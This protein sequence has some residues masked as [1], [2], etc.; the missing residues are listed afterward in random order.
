MRRLTL[1][2][3]AVV[4]A[5]CGSSRAKPDPEPGP[6]VTAPPGLAPAATVGPPEGSL[7]LLAP[8]GAVPD[9]A[10][11]VPGCNVSVTSV[12]G[13]D[14]VVRKLSTGR[15][16]A[17][18]G[19]GDA[20]VRLV[21][22]QAIAPVNVKLIRNY[23][24]VYDGLKRRPF[25]SVGGQPFAVPVGRAARLLV[26]RRNAVPGTLTSLGALLDP[27]QVASLGEQAIVPD[28]PHA[29]AEAALWV[30]RQRRDL[31]ITDPYE[32]DRKQF[33][34]VLRILRLQHPYVSEYW[35]D[36]SAVRV[37]FREGRAS[38]GI[39]PQ[40]VVG[41]L[42][43]Q[44]GSLGP[45]GATRPREGSSGVSPAWM[46][47]ARA[48]HPNCLYRFLDHALDPAVNADTA[49]ATDV[50]P[51]N[52]KSCDV[53]ERRGNERHCELFHADD[54]GFYAKVLFRTYPTSDCGDARGRVCMDWETWTR[55][56]RE[57]AQGS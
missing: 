17:A 30:A 27:P 14:D 33:N 21:A 48:K 47:A 36:P 53:L 24:D 25:N 45:I 22:A 12:R 8:Y 3:I 2:I 26:W 7:T 46:I 32:L 38:I 9:T 6:K 10:Q 23:A 1:V 29:I 52:R 16:D 40:A 43:Q 4:L 49:L 51:A 18:L 55:A 57:V 37:A 35:R 39:A 31:A 5:G 11:R 54:E 41:A 42:E 44:P 28:D 15:Y 13:S 50:A 56:W 34:A 19:N 20:M